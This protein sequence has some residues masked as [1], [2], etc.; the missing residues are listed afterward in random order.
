MLDNKIKAIALNFA[1]SK[2]NLFFDSALLSPA[3]SVNNH[4][5]HNAQLYTLGLTSYDAVNILSLH[6]GF[7]FY[8]CQNHRP[9]ATQML[10]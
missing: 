1:Y 7:S 3:L 4:L 2:T 6:S 8:G 9:N 10:R 5:Y